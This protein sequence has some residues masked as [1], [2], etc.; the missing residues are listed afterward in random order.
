M[1]LSSPRFADSDRLTACAANSPPMKKG[2]Q[3]E[4]VQRV[5]QALI[6][7]GF[8][9]PISTVEFGSPDG[10]FGN[11]T[12]GR[13]KDF[14]GRHKLSADGIVG[15][16]TM[17]KLDALLPTAGAPLP[18]L[19]GPLNLTHK[20]RL[21]LRTINMPNVPEFTQLDSANEVYN[22][23]GIEIEFASGMSL[24]LGDAE[25][26]TLDVVD[27]QCLWDQVSD[28]QALLQG[29]GRDG[30]GPRDV[31]AY[32]A[33]EI[34]E[35]NGNKLDGCA[36]HPPNRPAVFLSQTSTRFALAHEVGHVLLSSAFEPVH[37]DHD[38][39]N[40]M[41]GGFLGNLKRTPPAI[42]QAQRIQIRK[43]PFLFK[44]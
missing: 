4:A 16:N 35:T 5:Q 15:K 33:K 3:G 2:E 7:L 37:L 8:S 44:R 1:A 34:R 39:T 18:P 12:F 17:A 36:G 38:N 28:E 24:A 6:D 43:S 30:V 23:Y 41:F 9:M 11:E 25:R 42:N 20:V 32:F 19:P 29:K 10:I 26:I 13:V 31:I 40:L 22:Q 21:H 14:Q 27:G